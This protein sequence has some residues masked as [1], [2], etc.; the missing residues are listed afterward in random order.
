VDLKNTAR[1]RGDFFLRRTGSAVEQPG[2]YGRL[3]G[4]LGVFFPQRGGP[5]GPPR[6]GPG[7][8][9]RIKIRTAD[10]YSG[11]FVQPRKA[12]RVFIPCRSAPNNH[13]PPSSS[14]PPQREV[15][16]GRSMRVPHQAL[17]ASASPYLL[18]L[19]FLTVALFCLRTTA[20]FCRWASNPTAVGTAEPFHTGAP[21]WPLT[22][23]FACL[24]V[25]RIQVQKVT[26][27]QSVRVTIWVN[28][29]TWSIHSPNSP[30]GGHDLDD[31][32]ECSW[33]A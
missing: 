31:A 29:C 27:Q 22:L 17:L 11:G 1:R 19:G 8:P 30:S 13:M 2:S 25:K 15:H 20:F 18:G 33:W 21:R 14:S 4:P 6:S 26:R 16:T 28:S 5:G 9:G 23:R 3:R 10:S 32:L 12:A 24:V 7:L